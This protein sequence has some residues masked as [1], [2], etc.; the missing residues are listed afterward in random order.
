[1]SRKVTSGDQIVGS[2]V[3]LRRKQHA[4]SEQRLARILGVSVREIENFES[5][6]ARMGAVRLGNASKALDAPIGY[7][8]AALSAVN[9]SKP[10]ASPGQSLFLIPGAADLLSAYSRIA[11]SQLR[12]AVLKL[13]LHLARESR[14]SESLTLGK[15]PR[16]GRHSNS[17]AR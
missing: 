14:G 17:R 4:M 12:G 10:Q 15:T 7:F 1:M 5:G 3:R 2:R 16:Q 13:V 9:S 8:F 11:N 6:A